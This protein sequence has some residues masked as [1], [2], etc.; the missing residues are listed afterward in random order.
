MR[1]LSLT[2]LLVSACGSSAPPPATPEPSVPVDTAAVYGELDI[3]ADYAS[4][5]KVTSSPHISPTHGKR[6]VEIYVNDVGYAA[7]IDDGA[8]IPVGTVVV[9]TSWENER[10]K[11]GAVA[12][13]IFVMKKM[14]AG[15]DPDHEDWYYAIHWSDVPPAWQ[16]NVGAERVYWRSPSK[17]VSYCWKCHDNYHRELGMPAKGHRAWETAD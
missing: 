11:P 5:H 8:D 9:K 7:Y 16:K 2:L 6:F 3:G 4:Y 13:P 10:G 1:K 12:G 14:E 15:F 17:K